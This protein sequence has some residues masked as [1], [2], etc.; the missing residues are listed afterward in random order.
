MKYTQVFMIV[1]FVVVALVG[2]R[3]LSAP[4]QS[5]S[6]TLSIC[7]VTNN[8]DD[9]YVVYTRPQPVSASSGPGVTAAN[10]DWEATLII[11]PQEKGF[12]DVV[13]RDPDT[14]G[15]QIKIEPRCDESLP[16]YYI[17]GGIN[18]SGNCGQRWFK[19]PFAL[20]VGL[21]SRN[22][23]ESFDKNAHQIRYCGFQTAKAAINIFADGIQLESIRNINVIDREKLT[24][25]ELEKECEV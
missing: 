23:D 25:K 16:T 1:I 10:A 11:K 7:A 5:D 24:T 20:N 18:A 12:M 3:L 15:S 14:Y 21:K 19:G 6:Q 8:T 9:T 22:V 2:R 13:L 17:S 4:S